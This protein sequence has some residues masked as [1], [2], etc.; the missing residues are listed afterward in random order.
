MGLK[1]SSLFL[2]QLLG[3][4]SKVKLSKLSLLI[5]QPI[6]REQERE[7]EREGKFY[8][9]FSNENS[10]VVVVNGPKIPDLMGATTVVQT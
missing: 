4:F 7:R 9:I 5:V 6:Q 3:N 8:Y 10:L 1:F 2:E